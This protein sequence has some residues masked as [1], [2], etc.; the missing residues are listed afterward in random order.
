MRSH[1]HR[2]TDL[3]ALVMAERA[4]LEDGAREQYDDD[5]KLIVETMTCGDCGES[6]NDALIGPRTPAPSA[7]CPF[8]AIHPEIRE[9]RRLERRTVRP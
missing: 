7:R 9:L 8:E 3:R 2:T 6:W 4:I 1:V 5:G